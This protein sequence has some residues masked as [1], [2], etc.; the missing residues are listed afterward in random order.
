LNPDL[1]QTPCFPFV[2]LGVFNSA[3]DLV[4]SA[5]V[6]PFPLFVLLRSS[7]VLESLVSTAR[8]S[9]S[10]KYAKTLSTVRDAG[11][12]IVQLSPRVGPALHMN[13][14]TDGPGEN[15][16]TTYTRRRRIAGW[17]W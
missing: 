17:Q 5:F 9:L 7:L 10:P 3:E 4:N 15:V 12:A 14:I 8:P 16:R 2:I 1:E 13:R 6:H 11:L